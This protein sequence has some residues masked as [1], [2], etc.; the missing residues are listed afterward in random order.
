MKKNNVDEV[1]NL[2]LETNEIINIDETAKQIIKE[3]NVIYWNNITKIIGFDFDG[4]GVQMKYNKDLNNKRIVKVSF[5]DGN[6]EI[7]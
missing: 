3:C 2:E 5:K 7:I 4:V 6:Y 1:I